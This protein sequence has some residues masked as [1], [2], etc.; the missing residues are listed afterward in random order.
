MIGSPPATLRLVAKADTDSEVMKVMP[1]AMVTMSS[2]GHRPTL[3]SA[4]PNRKYMITPRIVR[5]LG[6]NTPL[7][8][9][10]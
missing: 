7:K 10:N 3:P 4:Q 5:M 1:L 9:P 8:A 2:T 6:V